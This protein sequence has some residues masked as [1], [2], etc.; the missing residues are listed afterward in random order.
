[1]GLLAV[2]EFSTDRTE[3][4]ATFRLCPLALLEPDAVRLRV[5]VA[6]VVLSVLG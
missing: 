6:L 3:Q 5:T 2:T 4:E 1:M